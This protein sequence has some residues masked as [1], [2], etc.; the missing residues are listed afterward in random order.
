MIDEDAPHRAGG[1]GEEVTTV[2]PGHVGLGE[3][4]EGFVDERG[5]L[6]RV[7]RPLAAHV[8]A[9]QAVQLRVDERRQ[10]G[11]GV[12]VAAAPALQ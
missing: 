12:V 4:Q 2:L 8:A 1:D 10:L 3:A 9:R 6:Q 11:E 7:R 5:R